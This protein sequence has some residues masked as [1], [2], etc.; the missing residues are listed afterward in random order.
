MVC[1]V[2]LGLAEAKTSPHGRRASGSKRSQ[3]RRGGGK[4]DDS[5]R[6]GNVWSEY[7]AKFDIPKVHGSGVYVDLGGTEVV[8]G[9]SYRMPTGKCPVAGKSIHLESG[10]DFLNSI[11]HANPRERG[12]GFPATEAT[13]VSRGQSISQKISPVSASILRSWGYSNS[14]DLANCAEYAKNIVISGGSRYR[15]PFVY[16]DYNKTC[17]ILYSPMQYNQGAKYCDADGS[18]DEGLSSLVC[19]Y[20]QKLSDDATL[21]YGS[22]SVYPDWDVLCPMHPVKDAMFGSWNGTH[23]E[24]MKPVYEESLQSFEECA[25]FLFEYSPSDV[26]LAPSA[27]RL[28]DVERFWSEMKKRNFVAASSVFAPTTVQDKSIKTGGN[29]INWGNWDGNERVCRLYDVVPTCLILSPGHY[30]LTSISSPSTKDAVP[31]PCDIDSRGDTPDGDGT[32]S[33]A[34]SKEA[35]QCDRYVHTRFSDTCGYYYECS[36]KPG[37]NSLPYWLGISAGVIIGIVLIAWLVRSCHGKYGKYKRFDS[38]DYDDQVIKEFYNE[39]H[40]NVRRD[41][42]LNSAAYLWGNTEPRASEV[43]P[44]RISKV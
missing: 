23:C 11:A 8:N 21:Y 38:E 35:L 19:M 7:M 15:Y 32:L 16:D 30:A 43:T 2:F 20:P 42:H 31:Y 29:G 27:S 40:Q 4:G 44:V 26:D 1:F 39:G 13:R 17:Y 36:D 5:R 3:G 10:A 34:L 28:P 6:N 14:T 33:T 25:E 37:W 18:A 24:P 41:E 12:L 22:S 9:S